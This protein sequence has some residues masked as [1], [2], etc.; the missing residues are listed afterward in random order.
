[1]SEPVTGDGTDAA[2]AA[3][4]AVTRAL[5]EAATAIE[6]MSDPDVAFKRATSLWAVL[7]SGMDGNG[8]LRARLAHAIWKE[9]E[10]D[11]AALGRELGVGK[12]RAGQ[13]IQSAQAQEQE[14]QA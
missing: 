9:H 6:A 4:A 12:A 14:K 10:F 7:R 8:L 3:I 11:L 5:S 13:L 2:S 1:M